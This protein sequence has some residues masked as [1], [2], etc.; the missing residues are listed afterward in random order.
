MA[1]VCCDARRRFMED[2]IGRWV[3]EFCADLR[4]RSRGRF[5]QALADTLGELVAL[6]RG[7]TFAA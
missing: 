2:H 4:E 6:E 1:R 5:Y 7:P 3:P